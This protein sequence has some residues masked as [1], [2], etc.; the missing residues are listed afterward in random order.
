MKQN[1][2]SSN[3]DVQT[4][5]S[6]PSEDAPRLRAPSDLVASIEDRT[7]RVYVVAYNRLLRE[8]LAKILA[9]RS[10]FSV[11]GQSAAN[12][13]AVRDLIDS[14]ADILLLNSGGDF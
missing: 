5:L 10:D 2:T 6:A 8:T 1:I 14:Q 9:K 13:D 7:W 11:V 3:S 12:N 4:M